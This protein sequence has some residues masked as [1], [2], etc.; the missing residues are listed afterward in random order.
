MSRKAFLF[1]MLIVTLAY[2][3]V[4][5]VLAQPKHDAKFKHADKNKDG[6]VDPVEKQQ[7]KQWENKQRAQ[8]NTWWE[9]RADTNADG[10]V[11]STELAAWKS[12][13]KER[14]DLNNDGTIDAKERRLSWRHANSRVNTEVEKK[15]DVNADGW[16][17]PQETN[18]ML[19][20]KYTIVQTNGKA[21]VDTG[22][23]AEYDANAD[24][25]IDAAEASVM[26]EDIQ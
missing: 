4:C 26:K 22:I 24:G 1:F 18:A 14:I 25:V 8:V 16:L 3:I 20:D 12:L 10:K 13:E 15:Y 21:K 23:E 17:D 2:S 5:S 9:N 19:K 7:E 11:D 6:V